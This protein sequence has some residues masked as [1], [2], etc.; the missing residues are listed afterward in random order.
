MKR[1]LAA[2]CCHS[3]FSTNC[4]YRF[5]LDA[6]PIPPLAFVIRPLPN[7]HSCHLLWQ[8][9]SCCFALPLTVFAGLICF[10][11]A[12]ALSPLPQSCHHHLV[13]P[14]SM[15]T[16]FWTIYKKKTMPSNDNLDND[17][18]KAILVKVSNMSS[19]KTLSLIKQRLT[20]QQ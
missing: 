2:A 10:G 13:L 17:D 1:L 9:P 11:G 15:V 6:V 3:Y 20:E 18:Q 8:Q 19:L 7:L 16:R 4:D 12:I 14:P 5:H